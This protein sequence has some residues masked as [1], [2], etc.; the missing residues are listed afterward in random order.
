MQ[1]LINAIMQKTGIS[2]D[3]AGGALGVVKEFVKA[4]VPMLG[5][6]IDGLLGGGGEQPAA[7]A[8]PNA[9]APKEEGGIMDKISDVIPGQ[10]GEKIEDFAKGAVDKAG[11]VIGG[12]K[13]KIGGLFGGK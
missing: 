4:K 10:A 9:E 6:Q 8:A 3:Q 7:A 11:D 12:L 2:A 5:G 13:D 1:E